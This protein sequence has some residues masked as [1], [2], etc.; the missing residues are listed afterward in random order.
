[1]AQD[2][3]VLK[4]KEDGLD[5]VDVNPVLEETEK[6]NE[7]IFIVDDF[8]GKSECSEGGDS[9]KTITLFVPD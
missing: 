7:K 6:K 9:P 8:C 4:A 2:A 3:A 5:G 1:M